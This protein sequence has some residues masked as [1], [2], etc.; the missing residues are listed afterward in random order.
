MVEPLDYIVMDRIRRKRSTLEVSV[1]YYKQNTFND[2]FEVCN[3][4]LLIL[5]LLHMKSFV[6]LNSHNP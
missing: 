1:G 3:T 6:S 2:W 4:E 5:K